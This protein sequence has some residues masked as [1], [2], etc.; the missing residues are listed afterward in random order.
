M[1]QIDNVLELVVGVLG[2]SDVIG[3]YPH[4]SAVLGG[5][6]PRSDLDV[7]VVTTRATTEGERRAMTEG[8]LAISGRRRRHPEDRPV[9]LTIVV[10]SEIRPWRYPPRGEYQYGE[11]LR[12]DYEAG[13]TPAPTN[14]PDLAPLLTMVLRGARA[15]FGP[16]PAE[17]LDPVPARDL[18]RAIVAGIPG[19]LDDL[20]GDEANVLLTF[21]RIWATL[22]T[23]E[24]HSKGDA[25]DWVIARLPAEHRPALDQARGVYLGTAEDDWAGR[26]EAVRAAVAVMTA[27]ID[28]ISAEG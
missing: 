22:T 28:R 9:E 10:Q 1:T 15:F 8:L 12:A 3:A 7:L 17:I 11:W 26:T 13:M 5:L 19:L 20:E 18:R 4:G 27:A 6:R 23:G 2:A 24:I 14:T 21:A 25:A 16:P